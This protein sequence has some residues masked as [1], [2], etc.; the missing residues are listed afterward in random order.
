MAT[1]QE[2]LELLGYI[3]VS[4]E[5]DGVCPYFHRPVRWPYTHHIHVVEFGGMASRKVIS[6]VIARRAFWGLTLPISLADGSAAICDLHGMYPF[7]T[8]NS[9]DCVAQIA[10]RVV[11]RTTDGSIRAFSG[12]YSDF[13]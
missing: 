3:H 1:Y 11:G 6:V 12:P 8:D 2:P 7:V 5:D 10:L 4:H 9:T 13:G